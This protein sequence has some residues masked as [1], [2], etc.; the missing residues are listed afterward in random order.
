MDFFLHKKVSDIGFVLKI[1]L[2]IYIIFNVLRKIKKY[3]KGDG[4]YVIMDDEKPLSVARNR[5]ANFLDKLGKI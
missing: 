2:Y 1:S 4:G 5:K 3:I